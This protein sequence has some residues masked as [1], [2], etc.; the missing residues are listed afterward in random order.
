MEL[1]P[2]DNVLIIDD[3]PDY[4]KLL[5]RF[6]Q[7]A[8]PKVRVVE[9]DPVSEPAPGDGF[10]WSRFDLLMLDY[11]L[12]I[13]ETGLDWLRRY[14]RAGEFP[15]TIVITGAGDEETAVRSMRFGAQDYLNKRGLTKERLME[16]VD[17]ALEAYGNDLR[18]ADTL[19]LRRA[20][21]N[22]ALFYRRLDEAATLKPEGEKGT[23]LLL[24]VDNY[25]EVETSQG[26]VIADNLTA[27]IAELAAR[28]L[29]TDGLNVNISRIG[30]A[31]VAALVD[32][33]EDLSRIR[34]MVQQLCRA[35]GSR[36]Y[37]EGSHEIPL[38]VS[39]GVI[40][41]SLM[42]DSTAGAQILE[43]ANVASRI[44]RGKPERI[45]YYV[46][47][48]SEAP[49]SSTP[50][51]ARFDVAEC[52]RENRLQT[53]YQP[54]VN[55][56]SGEGGIETPF[57][58]LRVHLVGPEGQTVS[59][60]NA[61]MNPSLWRLLDRWVVRHG[62]SRLYSLRQAGGKSSGVFFLLSSYTLRDQGFSDWVKR[63]LLHLKT[64]AL[65]RS[66]VFEVRIQD[67]LG[68]NRQMMD[69]MKT[70]HEATGALFALTRVPGPS[71]LEDHMGQGVPFRFACW[72][73]DGIA[74]DI[75]RLRDGIQ[76]ARSLG[77]ASWLDR[78][79]N[80]EQLSLAIQAGTDLVSGHFI[81]E[82]LDD[83]PEA[84]LGQDL[85]LE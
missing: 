18:K 54:L 79:E 66:L 29:K 46:F 77:L 53:L 68:H 27:H 82:P 32:G 80:A 28:E 16:S 59:P 61:L 50:V 81:Q 4:R 76:A 6:F 19:V 1:P 44:A 5:S 14:K 69:C 63:L 78:V 23:L 7:A 24:K 45:S 62:I 74:A 8:Y 2:L 47:D 49:D 67:F 83:I 22:K 65:G 33:M 3:D 56:G 17:R 38:A 42:G 10:D 60:E 41:L 25:P 73:H 21:F 11:H 31:A 51:E 57:Y 30:D 84:G 13:Q 71:V 58:R 15:A 85:L 64:P 36:P 70:I 43:E 12:G 35:L 20:I 9:M 52:I 26:I 34:L 55:V 39:V 75:V 48:S 37:T 40:P 72:S